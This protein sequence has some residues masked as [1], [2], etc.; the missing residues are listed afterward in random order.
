MQIIKYGSSIK[1]NDILKSRLDD[2]REQIKI[3][4]RNTI[5]KRLITLMFSYYYNFYNS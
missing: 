1:K 2:Q 4:I 3:R 5:N